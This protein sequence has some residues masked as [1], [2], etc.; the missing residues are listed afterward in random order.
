MDDNNSITLR[1]VQNG[2]K[3]IKLHDGSVY[4]LGRSRDTQI[5]D[6]RCSRVQLLVSADVKHSELVVEQVGINPS[7]INGMKLEKGEKRKAVQGD[8]I[9][10]LASEHLF[11]VEF[12]NSSRTESTMTDKVENGG[13]PIEK[14]SKPS[15]TL[16]HFLKNSALK[17][18]GCWESI[19]PDSLYVFTSDGI[20]SKEK[21]AA[22]DL[23]GT[24][25]TTLSGNVYPKEPN[26]WK[27]A[28][29]TVKE[30]LK[31]L[32]RDNYKIVFFTNQGGIASGKLKLSD[33]KQKVETIVRKIS[34]PV[35]VFVSGRDDIYR[36]PRPGMWNCLVTNKNDNIP[37]NYEESFFC[38]DAAGRQ[39]HCE[40]NKKKKDFSSSD[41]L[42]AINLNLKF[43]T[44][45]EYFLGWKPAPYKLPDFYAKNLKNTSLLEPKNAKLIDDSTEIIVMIGCP[46]SGKT[47]FSKTHLVSAGYIYVNRDT[48]K[49]WQKC[50]KLTEHS[51]GNDRSVVV[52][53]T[54]PDKESRAR[55]INVGKDFNVP[56]RAFW[57][58]VSL[59]H[60]K[61]NNAFR[62]IT[63]TSHEIIP[64]YSLNHFSIEPPDLSEGFSEIVR[65]NFIPKFKNDE[66]EK[67]YYTY[68]LD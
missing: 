8:I 1:S 46:G 65:V 9:E 52:D 49:T 58:N 19:T 47:F 24:I 35:Q 43:Y 40:P 25:I 2:S 50:V 31:E 61:H 56:V 44:P 64:N 12:P 6:P 41:R 48:L 42:F 38:G 16:D 36:K 57:M 39:A 20:K 51:V 63:D 54:N 18:A 55:Y 32:Y 29:P 62:K 27:I 45:E 4:L 3:C 5:T 66:E 11:E 21:I 34:L 14:T 30:K 67:L 22:F 23:D 15:G 33:F 53:N 7:A 68:L 37:V 26:D 28:Y 13:L 59:D 60:V 10:V 17:Q